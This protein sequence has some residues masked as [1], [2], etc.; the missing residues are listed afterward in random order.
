MTGGGR[1][2]SFDILRSVVDLETMIISPERQR[3]EVD[4]ER[5]RQRRG[6][7]GTCMF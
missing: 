5:Q 7:G 4:R 1:Q 2:V 3:E 6:W